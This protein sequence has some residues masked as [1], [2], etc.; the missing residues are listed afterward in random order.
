[1]KHELPPFR[2]IVATGKLTPADPYTA[3]RLDSYRNGSVMLMQPVVDSQSWK[4]KKYWA[5]LGRVVRDCP[6]PWKTVKEASNELKRALGV[7]D[8]GTTIS[9]TTVRYPKSLNDLTEPE[10][11]DFYEDAMFILQRYSGVDPETLGVESPDPGDNDDQEPSASFHDEPDAGS[12]EPS[13]PPLPPSPN[14]QAKDDAPT[15]PAGLR[16]EA[17]SKILRFAMDDDLTANQR[18]DNLISVQATWTSELPGDAA[19]VKT[20]CD[21]AAKLIKGE[22]TPKAAREYLTALASK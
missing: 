5:I 10:F 9:G 14:D 16:A 18:L 17:I 3:E 11:E 21:I 7:V 12:G 4:R 1:M 15:P 20:C 13:K 6:S 19:F 2:M 22:V 8:M